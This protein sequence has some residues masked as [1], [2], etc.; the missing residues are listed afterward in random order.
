MISEK[1]DSVSSWNISTYSL[2]VLKWAYDMIWQMPVKWHGVWAN[3]G[4]VPLRYPSVH[5]FALRTL[6]LQCFY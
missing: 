5:P 6:Q 1:I 3:A 4:F 2:Y